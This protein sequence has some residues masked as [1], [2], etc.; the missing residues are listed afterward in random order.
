MDPLESVTVI[1]RLRNGDIRKI[2]D[3][4]GSVTEVAYAERAIFWTDPIGATFEIRFDA[5]AS[6]KRPWLR[7]GI[8]TLTVT[9]NTAIS[10]RCSRVR[11]ALDGRVRRTRRRTAERD[12][13]DGVTEFSTASE[14]CSRCANRTALSRVMIT[15]ATRTLPRVTDAD[16]RAT[17]LVRGE[18]RPRRRTPS[19]RTGASFSSGTTAR[20]ASS[21]SAMRTGRCT[22]SRSA[23]S[24]SD[25][26]ED[27]RWPGD[28]LCQRDALGRVLLIRRGSETTELQRDLA[29]RVVRKSTTTEPRNTS[30]PPAAAR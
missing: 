28:S 9:M 7:R 11:H 12:E 24:A 6:W 13:S 14:G 2:I 25:R 20:N 19:C 29:G 18:H 15:M 5:R 17:R 16:G 26:G 1:E 23:L 30:R 4:K 21:R 10:S 3:P 8:K 27:V 22:R